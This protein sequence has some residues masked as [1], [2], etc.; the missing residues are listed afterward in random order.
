[1]ATEALGS[2]KKSKSK[3]KKSKTTKGGK[4]IREMHIRKASSGGFMARH[5]HEP[6][7]D[8]MQTPPDDI[9]LMPDVSALKDH[10]GEHFSDGEE[11]EEEPSAG[12]PGPG[13]MPSAP[14]PGA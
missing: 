6:S 10:M 2:E 8:G 13:G 4:K 14:T 7:G 1:M 3:K 12:G 9:H 11:P 5:E